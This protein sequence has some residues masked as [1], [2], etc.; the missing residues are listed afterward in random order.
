MQKWTKGHARFVGRVIF[1]NFLELP[2]QR[3]KNII[4]E[5]E[6]SICCKGGG[7]STVTER[8]LSKPNISNEKA[9]KL[10]RVIAE[11]VKSAEGFS[12]RYVYEGFNKIYT[13]RGKP[14]SRLF[15]TLRRI[16]SRNELTHRI[17]E[18][19]V[20][21]QKRFFNTCDPIDLV[22]F[23]QTHLAN[24]LNG[25]CLSKTDISWVSRLVS[26]L[27]VIMPSGEEK[28]LKWFFQTQKDINK[29][30]IK[31][32]LD[33]ENEDIESGRLKKPLTDN[34]I[35]PKLESEYGVRLSRHSIGHCRKVMGIPS[36]KRRL[37]GYKYP[38]LSANFSVLYPLTVE[39]VQ[40]NAAASP[41]I[42]EFRLK[43]KEIEYPTGKANVIY[44]GSAKNLKKRLKEHL[45]TNNK[46][47]HIRGFLKEFECSFRY[48]QFSAPHFHK[49]EERKLYRLF[50]TTYGAPPRCNGVRP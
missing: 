11:I 46:N 28:P 33:K 20:E 21:Q 37:S 31:Q 30:L 9:N 15:H 16:S 41:G 45:R 48:I 24:R 4:E 26:G 40:S 49:E 17:I 7:S 36:A 25:N 23:S 14:R 38:P 50:V 12:I 29:R 5:V 6:R 1:A 22:P 8:R 19:A 35:R 13:I 43:G 44:I 2:L 10:S 32:L 34:Q 39:S 27:S 18:G 47:G 42:Y 3:Y